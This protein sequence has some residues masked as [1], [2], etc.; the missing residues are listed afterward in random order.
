MKI[1][2]LKTEKVGEIEVLV[3]S[4]CTV[5]ELTAKSLLENK[6]AIEYT[7]QVEFAEKE[8][9]LQKVLDLKQLENMNIKEINKMSIE[10]KAEAKPEFKSMGEFLGA[11][12]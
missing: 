11:V 10:V 5:D 8:E 1:K 7:E 9:A 12:I 6:L 3:D 4:I 2:M